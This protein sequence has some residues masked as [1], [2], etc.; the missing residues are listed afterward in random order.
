MIPHK[1]T[2]LLE[3]IQTEVSE[4]EKQF[5]KWRLTMGQLSKSS[6]LKL[7][8]LGEAITIKLDSIHFY[9]C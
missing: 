9:A 3:I 8:Q 4:V 7:S 2:N 1:N 5:I 6:N